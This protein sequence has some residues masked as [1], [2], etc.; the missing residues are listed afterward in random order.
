M[1]FGDKKELLRRE[2]FSV[3]F[4]AHAPLNIILFYEEPVIKLVLI[5]VRVSH[6]ATYELYIYIYPIYFAT[7]GVFVYSFV[8][9]WLV[10][11]YECA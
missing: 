11:V 2:S 6:K 10:T 1:F 7:E 5:K 9:S 8:G 3:S 4:V